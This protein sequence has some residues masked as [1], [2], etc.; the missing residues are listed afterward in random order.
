MVRGI[1]SSD[2]PGALTLAAWPERATSP[3]ATAFFDVIAPKP[4]PRIYLDGMDV[5]NS[6]QAAIVGQRIQFPPEG[7]Q[8]TRTRIMAGLLH[9]MA[10]LEAMLARAGVEEWIFDTVSPKLKTLAQRL[11]GFTESAHEMVRSIKQPEA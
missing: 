9:G 10:F 1:T 6:R 5:T 7:G 2:L 11:L 3:A 8:R 4:E